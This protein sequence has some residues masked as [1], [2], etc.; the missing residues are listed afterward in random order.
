VAGPRRQ[1]LSEGPKPGAD[2]QHRVAVGERRR[3]DDAIER[4]L[5]DQE[6]LPETLERSEPEP[7]QNRPRTLGRNQ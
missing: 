6:M 1:R 3:G 4:A 2:L 5:A 7:P